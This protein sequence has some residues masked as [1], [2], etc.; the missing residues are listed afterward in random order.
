M[1]YISYIDVNNRVDLATRR[2]KWVDGVYWPY[3]VQPHTYQRG[4][5]PFIIAA[6][7]EPWG[8]GSCREF[9]VIMDTKKEQPA[10]LPNCVA[11]PGAARTKDEVM[12]HSYGGC[13]AIHAPLFAMSFGDRSKHSVRNRIII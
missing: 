7:T 4:K 5:W 9:S 3:D 8:C 11:E 13:N 1:L 6:N 10:S 12:D 2:G